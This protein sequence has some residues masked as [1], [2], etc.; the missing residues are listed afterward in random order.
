LNRTIELLRD[1]D[2]I[3]RT[4]AARA[5]A[6]CDNEIARQALHRAAEDRSSGVRDAAFQSLATLDRSSDR[7][8]IDPLRAV[9]ALVQEAGQ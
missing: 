7:L 6:Q 4:E 2:H 9:S 1:E 3:V 8:E 5:L